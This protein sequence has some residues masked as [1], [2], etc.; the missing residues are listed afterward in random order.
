LLH[1]LE[2]EVS[3]ALVAKKDKDE[4]DYTPIAAMQSERCDKCKHF[5]PLHEKCKLV[6]GHIKPGAW[7]NQFIK[8]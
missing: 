6:K 4:V 8:K 2:S 5:L 7:C 3:G 1:R